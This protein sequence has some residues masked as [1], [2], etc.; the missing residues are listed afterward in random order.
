ME[1]HGYTSGTLIILGGV[2]AAMVIVALARKMFSRDKLQQAH[3]LTGNLLSVVGT[4][5]AV[6]L[7]L[8]VVDALSRF[9]HATDVV[10]EE[11]NAL[12]D[13]FLMAGRMPEPQCSE[14]RAA[15]KAYAAEVVRY[16]WPLMARGLASAS[17]RKK[18]GRAHV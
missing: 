18:I 6:L 1:V 11:S 4:L 16:E 8:V 14:L 3:D 2:V 13:V 10:R 17:A 12:A 7:G 5:Y 15:C 9:S